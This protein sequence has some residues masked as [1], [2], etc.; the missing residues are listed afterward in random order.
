M[1]VPGQTAWQECGGDAC[2]VKIKPEHHDQNAAIV[3]YSLH[4]LVDNPED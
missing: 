3:K 2:R 1:H 4:G